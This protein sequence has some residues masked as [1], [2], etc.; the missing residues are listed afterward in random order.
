MVRLQAI[1][2]KPSWH[3]IWW[4]YF[5]AAYFIPWF[6]CFWTKPLLATWLDI[7]FAP[8]SCELRQLTR[9]KG[10]QDWRAA[11]RSAKR[12]AVWLNELLHRKLYSPPVFTLSSTAVIV[13]K[14]CLYH[15]FQ[16]ERTKIFK[17]RKSMLYSKYV[18]QKNDEDIIFHLGVYKSVQWKSVERS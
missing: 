13:V 9:D 11:H 3:K 8:C 10:W 18:W 5:L 1:W 17:I 15:C 6:Y 12:R 7:V 14:C 2:T 4:N 16:I